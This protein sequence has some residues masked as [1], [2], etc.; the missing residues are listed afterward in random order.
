[1]SEITNKP[2][3]VYFAKQLVR[4]KKSQFTECLKA[5][6]I[7]LN[8]GRYENAL[9]FIDPIISNSEYLKDEIKKRIK[10]NEV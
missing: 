9:H 7:C 1:M 8:E 2:S 4:G 6:Q 10:N 3:D 5:V